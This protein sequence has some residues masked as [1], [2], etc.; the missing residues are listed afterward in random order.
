MG[1]TAEAM[2]AAKEDGVTQLVGIVAAEIFIVLRG[3]QITLGRIKPAT[4][5]G[6]NINGTSSSGD[7]KYLWLL[8]FYFLLFSFYFLLFTFYFLLYMMM[9]FLIALLNCLK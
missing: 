6:V 4:I 2:T 8:T 7:K 5:S 9:L 3:I 1:E